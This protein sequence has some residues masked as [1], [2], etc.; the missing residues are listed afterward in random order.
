MWPRLLLS[1]GIT[2][3][4]MPGLAAERY[5]CAADD[6]SIKL[7]V[8]SG[9]SDAPGHRLNHFRGLMIGKSPLIPQDFRKLTL[10]SGQLTQNWASAGDLRLAV[11]TY[12]GNG[13]NAASA[14]L[15]IVASGKDEG[16]PMPGSYTLTFSAPDDAKPVTLTGRL[17]CSAK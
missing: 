8:D 16:A 6:A 2:A 3:I 10:D 1:L 11:A 14:E 5:Y 7:S 15:L 4:A 12:N 17:T 9:F 13:D